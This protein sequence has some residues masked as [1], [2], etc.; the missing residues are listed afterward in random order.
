MWASEAEKREQFH[1]ETL[2]PEEYAYQ[3]ECY[4]QMLAEMEAEEA[5]LRAAEYDA[6][7]SDPREW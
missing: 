1:K 3:E 7:M 6:R 4:Q 5:W 2:S